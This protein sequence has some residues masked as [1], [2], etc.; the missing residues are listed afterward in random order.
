MS[1]IPDSEIY[2]QIQNQIG[3]TISD[4]PLRFIFSQ[5]SLK[6]AWLIGIFGMIFFIIFNAKRK[7]RIVPIIE[8]IRNTTIDF[9]KTIGNLYYLE[10]NHDDT[11]NKK[12]NYF[13]EKIR[14][15]FMLDCSVLN[16]DFVKKLHQK[17]GKNLIDIQNVVF[18]INAYKKSPHDSIE[19]DLIKIN[20]AIEKIF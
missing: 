18:L 1:Y 12:I 4:S 15:D 6:W 9:A 20:N 19:D 17:S 14:S 3:E 8:P 13:L 10:G 7:Q 11:I 5:R 2:W 16:D